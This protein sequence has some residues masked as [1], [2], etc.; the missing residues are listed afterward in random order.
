MRYDHNAGIAYEE[1]KATIKYGPKYY[2]KIE[3]HKEKPG[4][5]HDINEC[6]KELVTQYIPKWKKIL[7]IGCGTGDFINSMNKTH[8]LIY[9]YDVMKESV[10]WLKSINGYLDPNNDFIGDILGFSMWDV[11]EHIADPQALLAL[12]P[13]R[14]YL[15][16]S[17]PIFDNLY[18]IKDS[19]HYRPKE[20]L[21]YFTH[22]GI[23]SFLDNFEMIEYNDIETD[24]GRDSIRTYVFR[25][26]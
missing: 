14:C 17:I 9:G 6:R 1:D 19:K 7:D 24:L 13:R 21:W 11:L 18:E 4:T 10:S 20:H 25:K 23:I 15:F 3:K 22:N 12:M 8:L 16:L 5:Y 2:A 26:L